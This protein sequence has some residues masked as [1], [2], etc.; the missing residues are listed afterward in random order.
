MKRRVC[1]LLLAAVL[2]L[3]IGGCASGT[4]DV[5]PTS[6][7]MGAVSM[8][9]APPSG[10]EIAMVA[11]ENTVGSEYGQSVWTTVSRVAGEGAVTSGLYRAGEGDD[12]TVLASLEL[13]V[14]GGARLV[15]LV[16]E[17]L[18]PVAAKAQRLYPDQEFILLGMPYDTAVKSNAVQVR[19]SP[20]QGGWLA[21]YASV[22]ET[23]GNIG[24]TAPG[25]D[26]EADRYA[27]GFLLGADA[28]ARDRQAEAGSI[29][30]YPVQSGEE[31]EDLATML[32]GLYTPEG[33]AM[34]VFFANRPSTAVDAFAAAAQW[35]GLV[36]GIAPLVG[37]EEQ[38]LAAIQHN[39]QNLL[40]AL[41]E[42]WL[43]GRFPGGETVEG[44]VEGGE[45]GLQLPQA[46]LQNFSE[47]HYQTALDRFRIGN[48]ATQIAVQTS[49]D[50][51]G[52]LPAPEA[53]ELVY[54]SVGMPLDDAQRVQPASGPGQSTAPAEDA[55]ALSSSV[56]PQT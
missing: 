46:G 9:E 11:S 42:G 18:A 33:P 28:A 24:F 47:Q 48:L 54:V 1:A 43:E 14:K 23:L 26:E 30:A 20:E 13:A 56:S 52:I 31:N 45:I 44:T 15:L 2:L 50:A 5:S 40:S 37:S 22:Y 41:M 29:R 3:G 53:L 7:A 17:D 36:A 8:P 12:E 34:R 55:L 21:G 19:Y 38:L 25:D 49:P 35:G 39:P 6:M 27:L 10:A 32:G 4:P 51:E 16:G